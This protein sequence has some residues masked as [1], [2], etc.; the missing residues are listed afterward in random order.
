MTATAEQ[1]LTLFSF[2]RNVFHLVAPPIDLAVVD[3]IYK[4]L[5]AI[6]FLCPALLLSGELSQTA[7]LHVDTGACLHNVKLTSTENAA[8]FCSALV[9]NVGVTAA[10]AAF[11]L[12]LA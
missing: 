8:V 2:S 3:Y 4:H 6:G 1:T 5:T 7:H 9:K 12:S 11:W 10:C